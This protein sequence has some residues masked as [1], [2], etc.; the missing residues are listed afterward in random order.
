MSAALKAFDLRTG[1]A[2]RSAGLR[3]RL[4]CND[5]AVVGG[6]VYVTDSATPTVLRLTAGPLGS[7]LRTNQSPRRRNRTAPAG[8]DRLRMTVPPMTTRA[9]G[10]LFRI[11]VENGRAG[12]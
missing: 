4:F 10:G 6:A 9:A 2:K 5:I 12:A 7:I 8:R 3:S 11:A 1:A